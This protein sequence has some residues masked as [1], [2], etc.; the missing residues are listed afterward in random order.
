MLCSSKKIFNNHTTYDVFQ[1]FEKHFSSILLEQ[2]SHLNHFQI[3]CYTIEQYQQLNNAPNVKWEN[4]DIFAYSIESKIVDGQYIVFAAIIFAPTLFEYFDLTKEE[5][6]S[7]I[8][9]ELG[10]I[11][12][13][14]N[15][16]LTNAG[17]MMIELK[18][19]EV[20]AK[21]GLA[22]SLKTLLRKLELSNL[23]YSGQCSL[24]NIRINCLD[25]TNK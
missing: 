14:F 24:L 10:H 25:T 22:E 2:F 3:D 20:A 8:A 9:H 16:N 18:A 13:Y 19:D 5:I 17:N 23:Y 1:D 6:W 12:H 11:I 4:M 21:L 7:A 15:E